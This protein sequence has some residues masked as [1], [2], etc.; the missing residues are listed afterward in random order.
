M[1]EFPRGLLPYEIFPH[2]F[3]NQFVFGGAL[4]L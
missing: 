3:T 4:A 1:V 2:A